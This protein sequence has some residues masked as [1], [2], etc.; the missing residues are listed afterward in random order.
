LEKF[1]FD[2][3]KVEEEV[4]GRGYLDSLAKMRFLKMSHHRRINSVISEV[5]EDLEESKML[6][7]HG[8]KSRNISE[9]PFNI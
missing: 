6:S 4:T 8:L 7:L 2:V 3:F 5:P 1:V 9:I